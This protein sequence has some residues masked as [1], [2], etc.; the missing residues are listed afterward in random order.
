MSERQAHN[1]AVARRYVELYNTDPERFVRECYHADYKV[2]VMGIGWYDGI[3]K[4]IDVEKA[5]LKAAPGRR[6]R[7]SHG[8]TMRRQLSLRLR[9]PQEFEPAARSSPKPTPHPTPE[10]IPVNQFGR[11]GLNFADAPRNFLIPGVLC[12]RI[13]DPVQTRH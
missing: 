1:L 8:H 4:F 11:A 13:W 10:F 5:V 9:P 7:V 6:M 2:G 3:E 12:I